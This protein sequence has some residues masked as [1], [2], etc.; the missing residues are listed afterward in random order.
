MTHAVPLDEI[1]PRGFVP[2][3]LQRLGFAL[4]AAGDNGRAEAE[5]FVRRRFA[6]RH[7]AR[8]EHFLPEL[9]GLRAWQGLCGV[10]G[11]CPA[12]GHRLYAEQYLAQPV[13]CAIAARL[14][15]P[16]ARHDV[17]EI[18][19]LASG[20]RG[21]SLL[22]FLVLGE[23]LV[24]AGPRFAIFTATRRVEGLLDR[25]GFAPTVL[26]DA[27]PARLPDAGAVWGR[28]Y[29]E[30]PRVLCGEIAPAVQRARRSRAYRIAATA[31]SPQAQRLA[32]EYRRRHP[33]P[34]HGA[35]A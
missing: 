1:G 24:R 23:L 29:D 18:G 25:L 32:G 12:Q 9:L 27:D 33:Q 7:H 30:A 35:A 10:V 34:S 14:G 6:D 19:N 16:V 13:E 11:L 5:A 21:A 22:L 31:L 20:R 15:Q 3:R 4:H 28:Y 8:V 17:V 26:C 2:R